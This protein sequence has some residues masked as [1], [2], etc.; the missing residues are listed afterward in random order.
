MPTLVLATQN[1]HKTEEVRAILGAAFEVRDLR[2][3]G[4]YAAPD[5]TGATLGEN[6]VL[7]ALAASA[8]LG[9]DH[10]VLA[11]DTGLEVDALDGDPGVNSA[12]YAG[13][14]GDDAANRARLVAELK[15]ANV[16]GKRR[17]ARFRCALAL[18][19]AGQVVREFAGTIE[20]VVANEEKGAGGFG[21]DALFIPEG[22]C[23]TFGEL[24]ASIKN[25]ISHRARALEEF[26]T[27]WSK[28]AAKTAV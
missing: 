12:R 3:F 6:A 2:S 4:L 15:K 16:R 11:D 25:G 24:S 20:G 23:Q 7:K 13:R 5:E 27:F 18:V 10:W 26:K 1:P 19:K 22:R 8:E 28:L 14:P 21:Y 9:D 17:R